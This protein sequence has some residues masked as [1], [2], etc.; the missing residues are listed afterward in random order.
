MIKNIL[1]NCMGL[2]FFYNSNAQMADYKIVFDIT[3][4]DSSSQ[5]AVVREAK[6]IKNANPDAKLEVV[7]YGQG[8]NL[9]LKDKS[10]QEAAILDLLTFK[11]I[12]FKVCAMTMERNHIDKSQLVKG[13]EVVPDGIYEIY[14]RQKEGWGY[15]KVAH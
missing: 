14:S 9:V 15:I 5:Q 13:V 7:V 6:L 4:K 3:S 10:A 11:D 2:F 12:S 1:L 8:L